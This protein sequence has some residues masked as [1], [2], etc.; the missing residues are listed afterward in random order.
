MHALA[1][2]TRRLGRPPLAACLPCAPRARSGTIEFSEFKKAMLHTMGKAQLEGRLGTFGHIITRKSKTG[3]PIRWTRAKTGAGVVLSDDSKTASRDMPSGWG[4]QLLDQ[5]LAHSADTYNLAD[6]M[7]EIECVTG[8][9]LAVG[10]VGRNFWPSAWDCDLRESKHAV[11]AHCEKGAIWRK[12]NQTDLLLGAVQPGQRIHVSLEMAKQEMTLSL[13]APDNAP[14]R[15]VT[16]GDLPSEVTIG[17]CMGPGAQK[18]RIVG[19]STDN[20]SHEYSGKTL[21]DLWDDD[22]I[23]RLE[24]EVSDNPASEEAVALSLE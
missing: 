16:V 5:W 2:P 22:N 18:V 23:Q 20:A 4:V 13:L 17:V 1:P 3:P 11:V 19:S 24:T 12:D 7:L 10:V 15:Q 14:I 21:K 9:N 6:V 8:G